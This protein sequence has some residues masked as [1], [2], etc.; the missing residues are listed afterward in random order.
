M[1]FNKICFEQTL[2]GSQARNILVSYYSNGLSYSFFQFKFYFDKK[3][4]HKYKIIPTNSGLKEKVGGG[5]EL[6]FSHCD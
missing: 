2:D 4:I 5:E 1:H 6:G 3:D